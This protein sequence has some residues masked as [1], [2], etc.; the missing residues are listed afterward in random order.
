MEESGKCDPSLGGSP[1][2]APEAPH[3]TPSFWLGVHGWKQ[4]W[5]LS[6][7]FTQ[8]ILQIKWQNLMLTRTPN[9]TVKVEKNIIVKISEKKKN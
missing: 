4:T 5:G 7:P 9:H 6:V 3:P 2:S 1:F 8:L